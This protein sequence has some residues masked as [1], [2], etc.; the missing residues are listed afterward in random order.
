MALET[1]MEVGQ[2]SGEEEGGV[3]QKFI[4]LYRKKSDQKTIHRWQ[5]KKDKR[6]LR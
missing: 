2:E 4:G 3:S 1:E 6:M 5:R